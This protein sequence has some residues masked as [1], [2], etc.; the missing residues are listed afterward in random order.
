[1]SIFIPTTPGSTD[2]VA[3]LEREFGANLPHSYILFL[4][5][6]D[7]A[8]PEDNVFNV[9]KGNSAGVDQFIPAREILGIRNKVDGFPRNVL[10]IARAT[11]GNF[12]YL[13]PKDGAV[14]F[15]DHEDDSA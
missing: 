11:A 12:V 6:H 13:D 1:M 7:G 15:W 10:P 9:G 14:Y 4:K 5:E 8:I 2:S 3:N